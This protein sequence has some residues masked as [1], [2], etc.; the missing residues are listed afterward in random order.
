MNTIISLC[1]VV[2]LF[3]VMPALGQP[4]VLT[5]YPNMWNVSNNLTSDGITP[6]FKYY[7]IY[8]EVVQPTLRVGIVCD[9]TT[10]TGWC[11]FG[12]GAADGTMSPGSDVVVGWVD[13]SNVATVIDFIITGRFPP[14]ED[15][16]GAVCPDSTQTGCG[17]N[18]TLVKG[19]R[20]GTYLVLEYTRPIIAADSCDKAIP[21][22]N[23]TFVI[24]STGD[25]VGTNFPF[26]MQ[27]HLVRTNVADGPFTVQFLTDVQPTSASGTQQASTTQ[28]KSSG[29]STT[30]ALSSTTGTATC[31]GLRTKCTDICAPNLVLSC[32]CNNGLPN[33]VCETTTGS[34]TTTA[35][36]V[37][38]HLLAMMLLMG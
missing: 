32:T 8:Y 36:F 26:N 6:V 15:C 22:N 29:S 20:S 16:S 5:G 14:T 10:T 1:S 30:N 31:D 33:A 19:F 9:T 34:S 3:Y 24:F 25:V 28:S 18:A 23:D 27:K 7:V 35:I 2:L 37:I 21:L 12:L 17:N 13:G 38:F 4:P 11:G